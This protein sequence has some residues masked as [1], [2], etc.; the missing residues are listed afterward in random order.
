MSSNTN[1]QLREFSGVSDQNPLGWLRHIDHLC[2]GVGLTDV[3][4]I[5]VASSHM[6]GQAELWWDSV[7]NKMTSWSTFD[8]A[9]HK[10]FAAFLQERW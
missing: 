2:H 5:L 10:H 9:F 7:E 6:T 1:S 3:E 8:Q 4:A